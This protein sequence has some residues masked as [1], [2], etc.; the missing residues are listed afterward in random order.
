[1]RGVWTVAG[2]VALI[3]IS[4]GTMA[5]SVYITADRL[6][7]VATGKVIERP[8]VIVENERI[9]KIGSQSDVPPPAN[10]STLALGNVT[11]LPGLIDMHVHLT[12]RV[13]MRGYR[14][15]SQS[16]PDQAIN[17]VVNAEA[18][19]QAGF[20]TV[21]NVGAA[22]FTDVALRDAIQEKRVRGPRL[23]VSGPGLGATGG[24]CDSNLLPQQF[25]A[26]REGV[27]DGP[28]E[29]VE[30]VRYVKKYGVDLIKICATGGVFSRRT[31]LGAQ[32]LS[33]E[34][35]A[36][37]VGEA[38]RLGIKVAAHAHGTDGIRSAIRAGVD[39]IEHASFL[40]DETIRL[41][42]EKGTWLSM[43]IYNTEYTLAQGEKNGTLPESLAK[44]RLV[45]TVQRESFT[46]ALKAGVG[47]VYGTDAGVHPHGEN[48][49]Q[50]SRMVRF[51]MTPLKAI[52]SATLNAAIALGAD[53][54]V[55]SLTVGRFADLIG[56]AG[57]PIDDVATLETPL[58]VVKGGALMKDRR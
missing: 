37:I 14:A 17:G 42:K 30:K 34:E 23:Y 55:G 6:L 54:D 40:D 38:R 33:E 10:A 24:H 31:S 16:I 3:A 49:K 58:V 53:K 52:Q 12:G 51:G 18:T 5:Q 47:M 45:G 29:L 22:G 48:G 27:A 36:A 9:A 57:N 15:L 41:A 11:L 35:M 43:D 13:D 28:W 20:T 21:R 32:Q 39:T 2:A 19:L 44:E 4:A 25:E 8:A 7:D 1:M 46:K 50:F 26:K 56:V